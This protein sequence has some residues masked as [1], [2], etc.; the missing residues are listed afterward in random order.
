MSSRIIFLNP[1]A[2]TV[3]SGG[4]KVMFGQAEILESMGFDAS[5]Y[6]PDGHP[7]WMSSRARLFP[8]ADPTADSGN[9]LVFPETLQGVLADVVRRAMPA[10][11]VLLC[12][13]QYFIFNEVIPK[14]KPAE[15]GFVK[16]L[17]VSTVAQGFLE[18]VLAPAKFE[19]VPVWI[20][21]DIFFAREKSPRVAV[22][23][24]KLPAHY[25]VIR[26]VFALKYPEF[27]GIAWDVIDAK[28]QSEAA[29]LLGRAGVFLAMCDRESVG[30]TALEAMASGCVVVGFHGYG[31]LEYATE[32]NGMWLRPDCLEETADALAQAIKHVQQ[33]DPRARDMRAAGYATARRFNRDATQAAL[34]RVFNFV[35]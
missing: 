25:S 23:P 18:R 33:G 22:F 19:V 1:F 20:D 10:R 17:T 21:A 27:A 4:I 34:D 29:E 28:S 6:S 35:R 3:I 26:N 13:N 12:Q 5:V 30:L 8:G 15:L 32:A 2:K 31:G 7:S 9:V 14:Y 16:M 24:R 11:K